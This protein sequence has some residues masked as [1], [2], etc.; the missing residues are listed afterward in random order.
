MTS[1]Y[2]ENL[3]RLGW[4][5]AQRGLFPMTNQKH[6]SRPFP[7]ETWELVLSSRTAEYWSKMLNQQMISVTYTSSWGYLISYKLEILYTKEKWGK[8]FI[9]SYT[10]ED[11]VCL[12]VKS[13]CSTTTFKRIK[14]FI[15]SSKAS[16]KKGTTPK[17]LQT[18]LISS[19]KTNK[20]GSKEINWS[21]DHLKYFLPSCVGSFG[22]AS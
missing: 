17:T 7:D 15:L 18:E 10:W 5:G 21:E 2:F 16:Q 1:R 22:D 20:N 12:A 13:A 11:S 14:L 19:D 3:S 9:V 8:L 4:R 6:Q